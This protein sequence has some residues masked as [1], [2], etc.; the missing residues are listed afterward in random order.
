MEP[1]WKSVIYRP[2]PASYLTGL[3]ELLRKA[4]RDLLEASLKPLDLKFELGSKLG[5]LGAN[6]W[7]S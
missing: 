6:P 1:L 7:T 4:G 3:S 2:K 5:I